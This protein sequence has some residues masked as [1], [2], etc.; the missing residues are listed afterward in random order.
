MSIS[1]DGHTALFKPHRSHVSGKRQLRFAQ[2]IHEN[3][4]LQ[5]ELLELELGI[6]SKHDEE[7]SGNDLVP[8]EDGTG[9]A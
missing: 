2:N 7:D 3:L 4:E 5:C 1:K 9:A 6:V 8:V